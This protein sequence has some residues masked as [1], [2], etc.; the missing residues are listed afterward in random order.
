[1]AATMAPV[2]PGVPE[3]WWDRFELPEGYNRAEIVRG[4]LVMTPS[5]AP[6]HGIA[7]PRI[8]SALDRNVP[9]GYAVAT[10]VEWSLPGPA[11]LVARPVP[12]VLVIPEKAKT[13]VDPPLLIV[14]V[15]SPSD[16]K[17]WGEWRWRIE[18]KRADYAAYGLQHYVEI[19]LADQGGPYA[20]RYELRDGRLIYVEEVHG[21]GILQVRTPFQ[22]SLCPATL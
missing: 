2:G 3:K 11:A 21:S 10:E 1:M 15:L 4:E 22:Y 19:T 6:A 14:E 17:R 9:E 7:I 5:P 12:D 8:T 20:T 16:L 18:A 13:V